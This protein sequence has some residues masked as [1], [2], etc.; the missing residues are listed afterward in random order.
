MEKEITLVFHNQGLRSYIEVDLCAECPRQDDKGCCGYYSPVFYPTD[1]G[2]LYINQP[3]LLGHIFSLEHL[4]ILDASVTVNN[5]IDGDSY[6]CKFHRKEGGCF[7][8]QNTRESICRHFVCPGVGWWQ[9][10]GMQNWWK[11]FDQL[12]NYEIQLNNRWSELLQEEGFSLRHP[13]Q[14]EAIF[15][16]FADW[17]QG[18][19]SRVPDFIR[20]MPAEERHT[21]HRALSFG[22]EWQL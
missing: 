9:E 14:R 18:E 22:T 13:R 21:L 20:Q 19:L 3:D 5:I 15:K 4:T 6:R 12:S 16:K 8:S 10:E 1:L 11:F 7:L 2:Y 17:Y